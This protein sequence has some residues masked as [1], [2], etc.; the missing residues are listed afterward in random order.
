MVS[1]LSSTDR[2]S[3]SSARTS[4]AAI[5]SRSL[6]SRSSLMR[7]EASAISASPDFRRLMRAA[8]LQTGKLVNQAG[9][10]RHVAL[11]QPTVGR[12]LNLL[13]TSYL[14]VRL[15]ADVVKPD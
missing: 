5:S 15:P 6:R 12:Y 7:S 3:A 11:P 14:L 2:R 13:E 4:S 10:G 1:A 9:L 8:C